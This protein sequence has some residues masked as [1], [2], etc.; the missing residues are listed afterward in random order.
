MGWRGD[1]RPNKVWLIWLDWAKVKLHS[2][3]LADK[4]YRC[5]VWLLDV[6][7][8]YQSTLIQPKMLSKRYDKSHFFAVLIEF[9]E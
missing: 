8:V 3:M 9:P 1:K 6:K 5:L 4:W 7:W 2:L